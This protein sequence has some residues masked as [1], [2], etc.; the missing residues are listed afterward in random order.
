[1]MLKGAM[2]V[3]ILWLDSYSQKRKRETV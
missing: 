1:M 3:A 2:I